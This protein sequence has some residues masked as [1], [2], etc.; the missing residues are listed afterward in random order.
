MSSDTFQDE[1]GQNRSYQHNRQHDEYAVSSAHSWASNAQFIQGNDHHIQNSHQSDPASTIASSPENVG[2]HSDSRRPSDQIQHCLT[3]PTVSMDT[4]PDEHAS[5][6]PKPSHPLQIFPSPAFEYTAQSQFPTWSSNFPAG[7]FGEGRQPS[8]GMSVRVGE[9]GTTTTI[10]SGCSTIIKDSTAQGQEHASSTQ[11]HK[12]QS[13]QE[14]DW[15]DENAQFRKAQVHADP[16]S[17]T[18]SPSTST[19]PPEEAESP[20]NTVN[21]ASSPTTQSLAPASQATNL[22]PEMRSQA[23]RSDG[24]PRRPMNAFLLFSRYRR[25]EAQLAGGSSITTAQFSAM[26]GE[27]WRKLPDERRKFWRDQAAQLREQFNRQFPSYRYSRSKRKS[28]SDKGSHAHSHD[29]FSHDDHY[30]NSAS[31]ENHNAYERSQATA[32]ASSSSLLRPGKVSLSSVPDTRSSYPS[33]MWASRPFTTVSGVTTSAVSQS[34]DWYGRF[35]PPR[36]DQQATNPSGSATWNGRQSSIGSYM[37]MANASGHGGSHTSNAMMP[38][39]TYSNAPMEFGQMYPQ[40]NVVPTSTPGTCASAVAPR[41]MQS[42]WNWS[43]SNTSNVPYGHNHSASQDT[44]ARYAPPMQRADYQLSSAQDDMRSEFGGFHSS[45]LPALTNTMPRL[46]SQS[47]A[48]PHDQSLVDWADGSYSAPVCPSTFQ[49]DATSATSTALG[50]P[51]SAQT[52]EETTQHQPLTSSEY[53][54]ADQTVPPGAVYAQTLHERQFFEAATAGSQV[55][56]LNF[57][58]RQ[59]PV[60]RFAPACSTQSPVDQRH[61]PAPQGS[62]MNQTGSTAMPGEDASRLHREIGLLSMSAYATG[63]PAPGPTNSNQPDAAAT[64]RSKYLPS[65]SY[66]VPPASLTTA[67]QLPPPAEL[68]AFEPGAASNILAMPS[69]SK[70]STPDVQ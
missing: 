20:K 57:A 33:S 45:R 55:S 34:P 51:S 64:Y 46:V 63:A 27:E 31:F 24:G 42:G 30:D 5:A 7:H 50:R 14:A 6:L 19:Y 32:T 13:M 37:P 62:S 36:A 39:P 1:R 53:S 23:P 59:P 26:L 67:T 70:A 28:K 16:W 60:D 56:A 12:M 3:S 25:K 4:N 44:H 43:T 15:D 68:L 38:A 2:S 49:T 40:Q 35:P 29:P 47:Q 65:M 11:D 8:I 52:V 9:F 58:L 21:S 22:D 17:S 69:A 54:S 18:A 10:D 66:T 48:L 61:M 41:A